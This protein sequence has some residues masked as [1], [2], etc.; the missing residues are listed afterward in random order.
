MSLAICPQCASPLQV[1]RS[2]SI[3]TLSC[4]TCGWN[5]SSARHVWKQH[6]LVGRLFL[7]FGLAVPLVVHFVSGDKDTAIA[8]AVPLLGIGAWVYW[9]SAKSLH[10]LLMQTS[11]APGNGLEAF[12]KIIPTRG[13]VEAHF[14]GVLKASRPRSIAWTWRTWCTAVLLPAWMIMFPIVRQNSPGGWVDL[15]IGFAVFCLIFGRLELHTYKEWKLLRTGES[16]AGRIVCQQATS[17]GRF[18]SSHIFYAFLDAANR[19]FIG[20][21]NDPS[22]KL[23]EGQPVI[24]FYRSSDPQQTV[25]I[26]G[27]DFTIDGENNG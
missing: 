5:R 16:S 25:V 11:N 8:V 24:V 22:R 6:R 4:S 12:T 18:V 9:S 10:Q 23:K 13:E 7:L 17:N 3:V 14:P 1:V 26:D 15:L 19:P 2:S 21:S 20:Q 27:Y